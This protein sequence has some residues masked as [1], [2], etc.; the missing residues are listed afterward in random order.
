MISQIAIVIFSGLS[1]WAFAGKH[2]RF[3][4]IAGLCG[5]PFWIYATLDAGQWGGFL[6]SLWFTYNHARGLWGH[7]PC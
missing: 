5:Q 6:I 1:I 2:Y 7:R 4:F 3:G